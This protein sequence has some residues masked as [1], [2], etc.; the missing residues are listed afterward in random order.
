MRLQTRIFVIFLM[1]FAMFSFFVMAMRDVDGDD[2]VDRKGQCDD[3]GDGH[4][5]V[6][7]F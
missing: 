1:N 5:M 6:M 2:H 3:D 7:Q 4:N